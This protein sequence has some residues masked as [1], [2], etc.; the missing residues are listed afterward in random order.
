MLYRQ[1]HSGEDAASKCVMHVLHCDIIHALSPL[2]TICH[3]EQ[4]V[5]GAWWL[6]H[7]GGIIKSLEV[8]E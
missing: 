2:F 8:P 3:N 5:T 7:M 4:W 6:I 1:R